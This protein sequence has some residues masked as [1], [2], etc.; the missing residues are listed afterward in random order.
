MIFR[1]RSSAMRRTSAGEPSKYSKSFSKISTPSKPA[2]R[3]AVS[4]STRVPLID[5]VAIERC[6]NGSCYDNQTAVGRGSACCNAE[7]GPVR[8]M[9]VRGEDQDLPTLAQISASLYKL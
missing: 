2:A 3:I 7:S 4:F 8:Y 1:P 9:Y 5:T 6:M